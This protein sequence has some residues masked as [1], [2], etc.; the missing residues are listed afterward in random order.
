MTALARGAAML[1]LGAGAWALAPGSEA[2]VAAV[3]GEDAL[4]DAAI[5]LGWHRTDPAVRRRLVEDLRFWGRE[6]DEAA[7]VDE[8][9]A[10]GLHRVDPIVRLRLAWRAEEAL[11]AD[12]PEPDDAALAA[13]VAAHPERFTRAERWRVRLD[14]PLPGLTPTWVTSAA[15]VDARLGAG[16]AAALAGG[17][18]VDTRLGVRA[19]LEARIPAEVPA[20]AAIRAEA[21]AD[22]RA[23]R[24]SAVRAARSSVW[25]AP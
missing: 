11:V 1:L 4:V 24:R 20:L 7:L 8:A 21:R 23:A 17:A 6:G 25:G 3:Q 9:V 13:W 2:T 16:V 18:W 15:G 22:W 14:P 19:R 5:G 10:L 12:V